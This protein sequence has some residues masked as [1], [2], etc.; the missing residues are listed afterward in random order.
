MMERIE[1]WAGLGFPDVFINADGTFHLLELKTAKHNAV[2]IRP[3]QVSFHSRHSNASSWILVKYQP[4]ASQAYS[5]NLYHGT[6]AVDVAMDGLK[7]EPV[8]ELDHTADW[9]EL[10]EA[11]TMGSEQRNDVLN[12]LAFEQIE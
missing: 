1:N 5:L 2:T 8:L 10:F 12:R 7:T 3:H 9:N 11:I 6:Q 4:P